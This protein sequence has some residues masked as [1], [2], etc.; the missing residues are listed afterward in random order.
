MTS[1]FRPLVVP[2]YPTLIAA[3]FV[4]GIWQQ[5]S[6]DLPPAIRPLLVAVV[7]GAAL[8]VVAAAITR[9]FHLGGAVA[10]LLVLGLIGGDDWRVLALTGLGIATLVLIAWRAPAIGLEIPWTRITGALNVFALCLLALVVVSVSRTIVVRPSP[11]L[12]DLDARPAASSEVPDIVLILLDQHGRQDVLADQYGEDIS[13]FVDALGQRGF[14]VSET[15]RSNYMT[16][17]LTLASMLNLAHI[18]ALGLP[19]E[20]DPAFTAALHDRIDANRGFG[21]LR[22]AGYHIAAVSPGFEGIPLRSAD[23]YLDG[24]QLSELESVLIQ[25]TALAR[26]V[27]ALDPELLGDDLRARVRWNLDP[28]NWLPGLATGMALDEPYFLYVHIPSPHP[29]YLF[30]RDGTPLSYR[31]LVAAEGA[32]GQGVRPE[33]RDTI[34]RAYGAQLAYIDTLTIAGLDTVIETVADDAVIIV[35]SDHGPDTHLDWEHLDS[36]SAR[37]RFATLFA[38]R[39][40]GFDRLFGASP[41]PVNLLPVLLNAYAGTDLPLQSDSSFLGQPPAR[42]TDI[43]NPDQVAR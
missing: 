19:P 9:D 26:V 32:R 43:G 12:G 41:T 15:S 40:P 36:V 6:L 24:G 11:G 10:G 13:G 25:N 22:S 4:A 8:T 37:E 33:M 30:E 38:A 17:Q 5:S 34:A 31:P 42:L 14:D 1:R 28:D 29:P 35:M 39:T 23:R 16:T 2:F 18:S 20:S 7:V 3:V 27:Q 21:I